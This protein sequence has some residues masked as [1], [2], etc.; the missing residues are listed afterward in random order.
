MRR[1]ASE[2]GIGRDDIRGVNGHAGVRG[3]GGGGPPAVKTHHDPGLVQ[4][5]RRGREM[6]GDGHGGVRTCRVYRTRAAGRAQVRAGGGSPR[7]A[8]ARDGSCTEGVIG[9]GRRRVIGGRGRGRAEQVPGAADRRAP[10]P[11]GPQADVADPHEPPREHVA[12]E[13]AQE[14]VDVEGHDL[15]VAAIRVVLPPKLDDAVDEADEARVR[16]RDA[17][18]VAPEG[19]E[20]L[21][22]PTTRALRI[23][24]PGRRPELRDQ[25]RAP[26]RVRQRRR[27]GGEGELALGAGA[28]QP[29]EILRAE[30]D[31][32]YLGH[33]HVETT[34]IYTHVVKEFRNPPRSPLDMIDARAPP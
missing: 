22:G 21:R 28:L 3:L 32:E 18:R 12:Q 1:R 15:R 33:T 13:P 26:G 25:R 31:R 14:L 29:R 10:L 23:D 8:K 24:D 2:R 11:V 19:L 7:P 27:A 4:P 30:D 20:H 34:M 5:G 9:L 16:D 17:V 6:R